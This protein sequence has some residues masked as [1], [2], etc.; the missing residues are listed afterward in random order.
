MVVVTTMSQKR[1]STSP[2]VIQVQNWHKTISIEGK[3]DV[4]SRHEKVSELLI[5]GV[6]LDSLIVS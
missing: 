2:S 3:L 6:M 5:N 4:I 1:K